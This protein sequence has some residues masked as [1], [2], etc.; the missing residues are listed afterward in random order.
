MVADLSLIYFFREE[1]GVGGSMGEKEE[2]REKDTRGIQC[3]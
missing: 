3:R 1:V 2:V